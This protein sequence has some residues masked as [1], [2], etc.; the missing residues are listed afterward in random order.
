MRSQPGSVVC[1]DLWRELSRLS[2]GVEGSDASGVCSQARTGAGSGT[3]WSGIGMCLA[4]GRRQWR[5]RRRR[6]RRR[7]GRK[8][9]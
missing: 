9:D 6:S 7:S 1:D 3:L 4:S 5:Q 8:I 2:S